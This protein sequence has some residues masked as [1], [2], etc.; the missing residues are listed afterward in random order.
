MKVEGIC[1]CFYLDQIYLSHRKPETMV[2][3]EVVTL[4]IELAL[5]S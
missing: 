5:G 2:M 4:N 1:H 3:I